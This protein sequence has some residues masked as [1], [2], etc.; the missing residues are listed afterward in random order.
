[1]FLLQRILVGLMQGPEGLSYLFFWLAVLPP[2]KP[3]AQKSMNNA[4]PFASPVLQ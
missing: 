1:V 3:P 4:L 2:A